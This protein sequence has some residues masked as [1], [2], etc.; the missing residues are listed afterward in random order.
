MAHDNTQ[1][2]RK[3]QYY[4]APFAHKANGIWIFFDYTENIRTCTKHGYHLK[5]YS[6]NFMSK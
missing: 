3:Q 1:E 2:A 6:Q 5:K 4:S